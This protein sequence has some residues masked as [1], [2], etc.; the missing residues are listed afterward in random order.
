MRQDM[1]SD[2]EWKR[3]G[4]TKCF[5]SDC[6]KWSSIRTTNGLCENHSLLWGKAAILLYEITHT[7]KKSYGGEC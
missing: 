7:K 4:W 1:N 3:L 6:N 2:L 5:V